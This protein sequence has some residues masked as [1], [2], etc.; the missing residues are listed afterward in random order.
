MRDDVTAKLVE[1]ETRMEEYN[2]RL[3]KV[4]HAIYDDGAGI[5]H[6]LAVLET[7][8]N[9]MHSMMRLIV[10]LTAGTFL[11]VIVMVLEILRG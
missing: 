2:A 9:Q 11:G 7:K 5:I 6:R 8:V 3:R 1:L 10:S 4:E